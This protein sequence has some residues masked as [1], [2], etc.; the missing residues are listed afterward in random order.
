RGATEAAGEMLLFLDDDM[1][2]E[3]DVLQHHASLIT[4]G[5]D[6][7]TG[8]IPI[9]PGSETGI[10]TGRLAAAASWKRDAR[11]SAFN[12]YSGPLSVRKSVVGEGGGFE[13]TLQ[14]RRLV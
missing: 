14:A 5:A 12:V 4:G 8:E 6:A 2:C 1:I 10:F 7:V 11:V 9:D 3:P 13:A